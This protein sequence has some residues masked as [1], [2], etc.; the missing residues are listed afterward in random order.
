MSKEE[1]V[2]VSWH[3]HLEL[4][5]SGDCPVMIVFQGDI[6]SIFG[7]AHL[8]F[9]LG[10]AALFLSHSTVL[11][12]G[13]WGVSKVPYDNVSIGSPGDTLVPL[14]QVARVWFLDPKVW[15][16]LILKGAKP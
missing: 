2:G 10:G 9:T 11:N 13:S 4:L 6:K 1:Y 14:S 3:K 7:M 16:P 8:D 12:S 15:T 5:R